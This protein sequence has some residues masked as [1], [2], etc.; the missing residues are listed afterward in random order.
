LA[1]DILPLFADISLF[2]P[3]DMGSPFKKPFAPSEI[4]ARMKH[5]MDI[6]KY[7]I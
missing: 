7:T 5:C 3:E 2:D 6:G 4:I 1:L